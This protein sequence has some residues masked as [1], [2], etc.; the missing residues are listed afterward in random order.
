MFAHAD[1]KVHFQ[2][3]KDLGVNVIH[4]FCVSCDGYAWYRGSQPAPT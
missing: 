2:W 1:P 3:Y 4:T